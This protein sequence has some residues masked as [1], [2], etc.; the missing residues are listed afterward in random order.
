M[1]YSEKKRS[2]FPDAKKE[3]EENFKYQDN[4]FSD[5]ILKQVEEYKFPIPNDKNCMHAVFAFD[6]QTCNV[7]NQFYCEAYAAGV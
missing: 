2:T 3:L 5:I 1:C 6:L 4:Q 7:E